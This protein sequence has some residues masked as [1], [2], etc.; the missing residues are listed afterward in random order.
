MY[1]FILALL[2]SMTINNSFSQKM[3]HRFE[4]YQDV[5]FVTDAN[6]GDPAI[7]VAGIFIKY[8]FTQYGH[9]VAMN[10][11]YA[12]ID[13][14][15]LHRITFSPWHFDFVLGKKLTASLS[16]EFG[17]MYR[18]KHWYKTSG[19]N[20]TLS[21]DVSNNFAVS[22]AARTMSRPDIYSIKTDALVGVK[23]YIRR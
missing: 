16:A 9:G 8:S 3:E 13:R 18:F 19:A 15:R 7:P 1:K 5:N 12:D 20:V 17:L 23:Y 4:V 11:E 6:T 14:S 2:I 10:Y 21:Y 22:T